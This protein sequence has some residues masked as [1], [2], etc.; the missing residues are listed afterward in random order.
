MNGV[1]IACLDSTK[2]HCMVPENRIDLIVLTNRTQKQLLLHLILP[3]R[4]IN[5]RWS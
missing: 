5:L 2:V 3:R 4:C 1:C